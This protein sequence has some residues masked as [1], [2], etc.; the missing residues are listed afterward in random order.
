MLYKV[1][2]NVIKHKSRL[3]GIPTSFIFEDVCHKKSI[4][5]NVFKAR[6]L[7]TFHLSILFTLKKTDSKIN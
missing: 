4:D 3:H 7:P 5:F 6:F 1:P 2:Q